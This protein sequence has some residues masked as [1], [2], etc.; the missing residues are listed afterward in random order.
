MPRTIVSNRPRRLVLLG[1]RGAVE[2]MG[3]VCM[4]RCLLL[5]SFAAF[6]FAGC[7][8]QTGQT[9]TPARND[10]GNANGGGADGSDGDG[11][12][13]DGGDVDGGDLDGGDVDEGD[14]DADPLL[15]SPTLPA[16][17]DGWSYLGPEHGTPLHIFG[18]SYD[19]GGN[20]WVAGGEEGLFLLRSG[21]TRFERFTMDDGLRPYGYMPDG[22]EPPGDKYLKVISVEGA[23][24]GTAFVGYAGK[25]ALPGEYGCE[26]NW[27]GPSPDPSIYKSGDADR[28][29]LT[30]SG[31]DVV[32]YDISSGHGI[33]GNELWGREK[34]CNVLGLKY[35][36][37]ME[38][39]WFGGNH[40]LAMGDARYAGTGKCVWAAT[41]NPDPP[42]SKTSPYSNDFGHYGCSGVLE[43][44]HPAISGRKSDGSCCALLSGGYYGVD[45]DPVTGDPWFG[46]QMRTTRF[47]YATNR[48]DFYAAQSQTEDAGWA[49]NRID[50][51]P[52]AA[53]EP[54]ILSQGDRVDD[55]VSG[56]SA[57]GNGSVWVSS[58]AHG[59]AHVG[60]DGVVRS[61]FSASNGLVSTK[62]GAVLV[63]PRDGSVWVGA[64]S[65]G[66]L[67]R[68][69]GGKVTNFS[70]SHFGFDLANQGVSDL[71][72]TGSGSARR[73]V[74]SF[75]GNAK[76]AG[77][78]AIY[79]GP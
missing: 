34:I 55:L 43:H 28:V 37:A 25:P 3:E 70:G 15:P 29:S 1:T 78:I 14:V 17:G 12:D 22:S 51:W 39:I 65:A 52:D 6:V 49:H 60:D 46:G 62:L 50:I 76:H 7:G 19:D 63:D 5:M 32:H 56:L 64:A 2:A 30:A 47:R 23:W 11:G 53:Q 40:G 38:R 44:A 10:G 21:E 20:L 24:A 16:D 67:S 71:T 61:R 42:T 26:D 74:V 73:L 59:L 45:V 33:V 9:Q 31:L 4:M 18:A 69:S 77:A 72:A 66:G 79:E 35:D 68:L 75:A 54:A 13:L 8:T 48:G 57:A 41:P 36:R 58:F 27:D